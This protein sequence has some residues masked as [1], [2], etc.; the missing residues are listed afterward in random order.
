MGNAGTLTGVARR[1]GGGADVSAGAAAA[2]GPTFEECNMFSS[3]SLRL[4]SLFRLDI[5]QEHIQPCHARACLENPASLQP[6]SWH[7]Q[8]R[9]QPRAT[10]LPLMAL[11]S[12]SCVVQ[13]AE[14]E[15]ALAG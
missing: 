13:A 11:H 10:V 9:Q 14:L 3:A 15:A 7:A 1:A 4:G 12:H 8:R 6:T 2:P 5:L